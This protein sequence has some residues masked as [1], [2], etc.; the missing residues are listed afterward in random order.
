MNE[1]VKRNHN[2]FSNLTDCIICQMEK[3][4]NPLTTP[5]AKGSEKNNS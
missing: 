1:N 3:K 5:C 4:L 2:N